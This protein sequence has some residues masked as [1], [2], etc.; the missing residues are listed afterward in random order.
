MKNNINPI[1]LK[2]N[3]INERMKELMGIQPIN[4]IKT[5]NSVLELTK[6][7]PD[8]K[9]YGIVRENHEYYI[10]TTDK[11]SNLTVEDF[12]YIGGLKNKK[13]FAFPSYAKAIKELNFKFISLNEAYEKSDKINVFE[14]DNLGEDCEID[15]TV[16]EA[17]KNNPWAI[18]TSSVGREDKEKYERCVKD[19]KKENGI[20]ENITE[21]EFNGE[22]LNELEQ[23]VEDMMEEKIEEAVKPKNPRK[24]SIAKSINEMDNIID[25][26]A[27]KNKKKV[28]SI[29]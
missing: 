16:T 19:V 27:P 1:G 29:R 7:G 14:N 25:E 5:K 11:N 21:A 13:D 28:Y 18:C 12:S 24:L 22:A 15:E 26:M 4:E 20:D 6:V 3:E 2:G 8:G 23:A 10:K 9:T 17:K